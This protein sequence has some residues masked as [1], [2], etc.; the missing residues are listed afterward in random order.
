MIRRTAG[1]GADR[2]SDAGDYR[3]SES[4][5][6]DLRCLCAM[7]KPVV[8]VLN[9]G[10]VVDLSILDELPGIRAVLVLSQPGMEG[11][12]AFA[13]VVSG[14]VTPCG[15]LTDSWAFRYEDYPCVRVRTE[16]EDPLTEVCREGVFVGYRYFDTFSVPV[17]YGFGWGL[18]YTEFS[19]SL[20]QMTCREELVRL[21]V[22]VTNTGSRYSGRE[23]VQVYATCPPSGAAREFRRLVAFAKT[24]LLAP[25]AGQTLT[26]ELPLEAL[27]VFDPRQSSWKWSRGSVFLW[28]GPSLEQAEPAGVLVFEQETI[29]EKTGRLWPDTAQTDTLFPDP[30]ADRERREALRAHAAQNGLPRLTVRPAARPS[31]PRTPDAAARRAE[32]I[33]DGLLDEMLARFCVGHWSREP[34]GPLGAE[35]LRVPGSAGETCGALED[36]GVPA[37]VLADG[38]AGCG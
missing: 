20:E 32:R 16:N 29:R 13:D 19:W 5:E 12:S 27:T 38:P 7:G 3:L 10:G 11:G 30:A 33:A 15:R 26:V 24:D 22:R 4:E 9:T 23:T 17:R 28:I 35:G 14:R 21:Q 6:R 36:S 37:L 31:A 1:E 34:Q 25:G 18:S 2:T 8:L